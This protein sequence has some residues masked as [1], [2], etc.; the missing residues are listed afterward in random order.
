[1]CSC[2]AL[3]ERLGGMPARGH[4]E[5]FLVSKDASRF[6]SIEKANWQGQYSA[7]RHPSLLC[8]V[9]R[10]GVAQASGAQA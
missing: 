7:L 1:M 5:D 10:P 3:T 9:F 2:A 4:F 6:A 8:G